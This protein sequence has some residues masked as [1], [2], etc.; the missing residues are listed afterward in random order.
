MSRLQTGGP[1]RVRTFYVDCSVTVRGDGSRAHPWNSLKPVNAFRFAPGDQI[2]LRRGMTCH[3]MLHP[4]GSGTPDAPIVVDVYGEGPR[5][6]LDGGRHWA[7]FELFNQS[8]WELR[9]L[10]IVGGDHYGLLISGNSPHSSLTHFV[11]LDLDAHGAYFTS[12]TRSDSG[13]IFLS[14]RGLGETLNDVRIDHVS[15][16]DTHASEGIL[17]SAGGAFQGSRQTL[18]T[19]IVVENSTAHDVYGDGIMVGEARHV[20]IQHNVVYNTGLC[21]ANCGSSTPNGLWEWYCDECVVQGNESFANHSW[22]AQDGGDFD[23]DYYSSQN[24]VQYNYGHDSAGYCIAFFGAGGTATVGSIFRYNICSNNARNASNASQGDIYVST[25]DG[26]SINGIEIY[27]NTFYW[28]PVNDAPLFRTH[29]VLF[30]GSLPRI[31]MNNLVFAKARS[32][33]DANRGITLD[34]NLYWTLAPFAA[35]Q[36]DGTTYKNFNA[37]RTATHQDRHSLFADPLLVDPEYHQV[38]RP[39]HAFTL[40]PASPVRNAGIN[41]CSGRERCSMGEGD[42]WGHPLPP[43]EHLDIGADQ[44]P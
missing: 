9:H 10:E 14:P 38:G 20:L 2:L 6:I 3:G 27:N 34:H 40:L 21:P 12:R 22:S 29:N 23:I 35:W 37:Y 5:P 31:F 13:E 11:L 28:N 36:F 8:Y 41:V 16:H 15:A 33:I 17:V 25:W 1:S 18:G 32:F 24:I 44:A 4:L 26:G 39:V 43:S 7:A 42:F 19:N 30:S